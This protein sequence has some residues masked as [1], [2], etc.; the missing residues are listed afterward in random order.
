[1]K[2]NY[3]SPQALVIETLLEEYCEDSLSAGVIVDDTNA[4]GFIGGN[5]DDLLDE[6]W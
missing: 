3:L 1:M 4:G 2:K 5:A 6:E